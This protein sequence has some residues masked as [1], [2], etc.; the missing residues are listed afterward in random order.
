VQAILSN[1]R[2]TNVGGI[3]DTAIAEVLV[4]LAN[5]A[6][7]IGKLPGQCDEPSDTYLQ[8]IEALDQLDRLDEVQG[9]D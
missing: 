7:A 8:L 2:G 9:V 5:A 4:R 6:S 3:P 1:Y